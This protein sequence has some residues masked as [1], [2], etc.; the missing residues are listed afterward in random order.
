MCGLLKEMRLLPS[1]L[2][3]IPVSVSR[4]LDP[5]VVLETEIDSRERF[6]D[7]EMPSVKV[8]KSSWV[9]ESELEG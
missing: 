5:E 4:I 6:R 1:T 8:T 7:W 9:L 2:E 3:R